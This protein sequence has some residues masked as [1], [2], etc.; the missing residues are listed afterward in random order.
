MSLQH[1][2]SARLEVEL[3][4][5]FCLEELITENG[6]PFNLEEWQRLVLLDHFDGAQEMVVLVPKGN[7]KTTL[8]A[9]RAIWELIRVPDAS[10]YIAAASR[11]QAT[12]M[13]KHASGFVRR[14]PR[15]EQLIDVK[16]GYRELRSTTGSGFCRAVASDA[17][18]LD[19]IG[20]SL[21]LCDELHRHKNT[22][23]YTVAM[24]GLGK[25]DGKMV[26]ISTAGSNSD[27]PLGKLRDR[28][29]L[30]SDRLTDGFH[31]R[32]VSDDGKFAAHEWAV[33]EGDEWDTDDVN[34]VKRANPSS[35]VTVE[36]LSRRKDSPSTHKRDWLRFACNQW[37][38][39]SIEDVWIESGKWGL[40]Y[41]EGACLPEHHP[42][43]IGVDIGL[44]HDTSAV[45]VIGQREDGRWVV[46]CQVF[47]PP[48][49]GE[50]ELSLVEEHIFDL[51]DRY[52]VQCVV[53]DQ[54]SFSRSAQELS[55]RGAICVSFPMT[56][57]RMVP[58]CS[59]LMEAINRLE[60]VHNGDRD[61]QAH[62]EAAAAKPTERG[63]RVSKSK[64][65]GIGAGKIDALIALLLAFS[66]AASETPD[67]S[68]EWI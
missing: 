24:N 32:S 17:D 33:P 35:F 56:N 39:D 19:G 3:F 44:R 7:G 40:L 25:R 67:V 55:T 46:E 21:F 28:A 41:E 15:L 58:A 11:D 48:E 65:G 34:V 43:W 66:V 6:G 52:S 64:S 47:V 22:D 1:S 12:L 29:R 45:V 26:T 62:V 59:R 60:L 4:E 63:V 51:H 23:L 13:Y 20:P 50:L 38:G 36:D 68:V 8:F 16:S 53:Y 49:G 61:L 57:V 18:T 31:T 54:W 30:L 14:N 27:S 37:V 10:C 5:Q 42:V 2:E 9:A